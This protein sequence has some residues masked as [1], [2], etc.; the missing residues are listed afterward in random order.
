MNAYGNSMMQPV[1]ALSQGNQAVNNM[2]SGAI[3]NRRNS[4]DRLIQQKPNTMQKISN[5][6]SGTGDAMQG[7]MLTNAYMNKL[8]PSGGYN[9]WSSFNPF[10]RGGGSSVNTWSPKGYADFAGPNP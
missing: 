5:A 8:D 1:G 4:M 6:L 7:H 2:Y 3:A 9:T 10:S